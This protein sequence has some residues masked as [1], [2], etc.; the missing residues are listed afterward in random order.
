MPAQAQ[1]IIVLGGEQTVPHMLSSFGRVTSDITGSVKLEELERRAQQREA[2]V[3]ALQQQVLEKEAKKMISRLQRWDEDQKELVLLGFAGA[4]KPRPSIP[5]ELVPYI[6]ALAP[7]ALHPAQ[8]PVAPAVAAPPT[9]GAAAA[10]TS[11]APLLPA[12]AVARPLPLPGAAPSGEGPEGHLDRVLRSV[13]PGLAEHVAAVVETASTAAVERAANEAAA[14]AAARVQQGGA[15]AGGN[16]GG[17]SGVAALAELVRELLSE[18][19]SIRAQLE[20]RGGGGG[21]GAASR[22]APAGS[23]AALLRA[24]RGGGGGGGGRAAPPRAAPSPFYNVGSRRGSEAR[25]ESNLEGDGDAG[26][27]S[28]HRAAQPPK[29]PPFGR[30]AEGTLTAA[31]RRAK[32]DKRLR[33]AAERRR[34]ALED[35]RAASAAA[36]TAKLREAAEQKG[37]RRQMAFDRGGALAAAQGGFN[38]EWEG[39]LADV[40]RN[41]P[42][43]SRFT[44]GGRGGGGRGNQPAQPAASQ[45]SSYPPAYQAQ[46]SSRP[47]AY[48][49]H[50]ADED[51]DLASMLGHMPVEVPSSTRMLVPQRG[52][53]A[54]SRR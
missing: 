16:D 53:A 32:G 5:P 19:R 27:A 35:F 8:L 22:G 30:H 46:P 28:Q 25:S 23:A 33:D 2:L 24:A 26:G 31:E 9:A 38:G 42:P 43:R 1:A 15:G 6:E 10:L 45:R 52:S 3:S 48:Q 13:A 51:M 14:A 44:E 21:G 41:S 20:A 54:A 7:E 36:K 49:A 47:S 37:L 12:A 50:L 11:R 39:G 4:G 40:L 17:A 18:Q 29:R 34:L